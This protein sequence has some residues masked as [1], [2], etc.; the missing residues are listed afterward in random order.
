MTAFRDCDACAPCL[1][2]NHEPCHYRQRV[3]VKTEVLQFT[4]GDIKS[5][6]T[7]LKHSKTVRQG[8]NDEVSPQG[9]S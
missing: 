9:A 1:Q 3:T 4:R 2:I 6:K 8:Y 5:N 7:K